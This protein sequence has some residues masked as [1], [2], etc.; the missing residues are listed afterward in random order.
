MSES[1]FDQNI[2][3]EIQEKGLEAKRIRYED[4]QAKLKTLRFEY[5]IVP[6]TTTTVCTA[7]DTT[8]FTLALEY[9]ACVSPEN[10]DEEIGRKVALVNATKSAEDALWKLEGYKLKHS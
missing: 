7:I 10:F 3:Q 8:G 1:N 6:N 9:S 4:I 5:W 2:E